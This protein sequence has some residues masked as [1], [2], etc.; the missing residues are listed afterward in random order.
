MIGVFGKHLFSLHPTEIQFAY[1]YKSLQE[2]NH[3][4]M[5][6][7]PWI[8]F[9]RRLH[10]SS[11]GS[12]VITDTKR[13]QFTMMRGQINK[14]DMDDVFIQVTRNEKS[15]HANCNQVV[16]RLGVDIDVQLCINMVMMPQRYSF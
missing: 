2:I 15:V 8:A 13:D 3:F 1:K 11:L 16:N 14:H 6:F 7:K 10:L 5:H 9:L 12:I 4:D